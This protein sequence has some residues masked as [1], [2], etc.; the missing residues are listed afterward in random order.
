MFLCVFSPCF[1]E[2]NLS[3]LLLHCPWCQLDRSHPFLALVIGLTRKDKSSFCVV[4]LV[5]SICP[6]SYWESL[7]SLNHL[8]TKLLIDN[9]LI[10]QV[11]SPCP[12]FILISDRH[13]MT[14]NDSRDFIILFRVIWST[15]FRWHYWFG[16]WRANPWSFWRWPGRRS[17]RGGS[18]RSLRIDF[19]ISK[20]ENVFIV[21]FESYFEHIAVQ[22][23]IFLL[24]FLIQNIKRSH[25]V[26]CPKW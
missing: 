18:L 22:V 6:W 7:A 25:L 17:L 9:S 19:E 23:S 16:P 24:I 20:V 2:S 12:S 15:L 3:Y 4:P 5:L 10:F 26:N 21:L 1:M 8:F 14:L 11:M 13:Q